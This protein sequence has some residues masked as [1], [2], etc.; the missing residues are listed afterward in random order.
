MSTKKCPFCA[1]EIQLEAVKCKHCGSWL[2]QQA[3]APP[4]PPPGAAA[5]PIAGAPPGSKRLTRSNTDR[6]LA[7]VCGGIAKN[8]GMDPTLI[9][10]AY[11]V[12]TFFTAIFPGI[13][14]YVLLAIIIPAE[15]DV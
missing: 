15:G 5:P 13:I 2:N 4:P 10:I 9:R 1:E 14:L 11:A 12:L 7:G 6:M 8:L 3:S